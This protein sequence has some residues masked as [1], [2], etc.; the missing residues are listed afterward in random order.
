MS[1]TKNIPTKDYLNNIFYYENGNLYWKVKKGANALEGKKAGSYS[2]TGYFNVVVNNVKYRLHRVIF[3]WH[4]GF[5][6]KEVDHING[7]KLDNRIENLRAATKSQNLRNMKIKKTN[8]SGYKN[9]SW[10]KDINKWEV[11]LMAFGKNK[12]IGYFK[13]LELAGLVAQMAREKYHGEFA[14]HF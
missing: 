8:T 14:R 9:V 3:M 7:D 13:D 6:P 4:Y 5:L 10:R 2:N 12:F 11:H 1:K